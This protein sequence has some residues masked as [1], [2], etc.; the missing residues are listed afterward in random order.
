MQ[1][2]ERKIMKPLDQYEIDFDI[3]HGTWDV[4]L[5]TWNVDH[6]TW[7]IDTSLTEQRITTRPLKGKKALT[8]QKLTHVLKDTPPPATTPTTTNNE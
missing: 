5:G 3:D 4:D 1:T 2:M 6:G 7:D 8:G